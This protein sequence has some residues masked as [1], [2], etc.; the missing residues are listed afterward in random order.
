MDDAMDDRGTRERTHGR[1]AVVAAAFSGAAAWLAGFGVREARAANGDP[2]RIGRDNRATAATRMYNVDADGTTLRARAR[3]SGSIG[4]EGVSRAGT[5]VHGRTHSGNGVSG[6][7]VV[8]IGVSGHSIEP[9]SYA[10]SGDS[11]SGVGVQGGSH[12]GIGVQGNCQ[13]GIAVR[14][15][16]VSE[17]QPAVQGWAQNGQ[18]GV[19]GLSTVLE[20][21]DVAESPT[22]VGVFGVCDRSSGRGVLARSLKGLALQ[23]DGRVALSTSGVAVVPDGGSHVVVHPSFMLAPS[24]KVFTTFLGNP[25]TAAVRWV[26]V[27]TTMNAFTIHLTGAVNVNTRIAWLVLD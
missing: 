20:D 7:S 17:T 10:V 2:V 11:A 27:N 24:A 6:E 12:G 13:F 4:L 5:G 26:Q 25:G 19:M 22:D 15:G 8:G 23:T 14:G 3:G 1:R 21:G 18:T 9:G 16:N